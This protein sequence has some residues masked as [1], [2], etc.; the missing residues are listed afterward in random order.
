ML[1]W[2]EKGIE[3]YEAKAGPLTAIVTRDFTYSLENETVTYSLFL[4]EVEIEKLQIHVSEL[5]IN[6]WDDNCGKKACRALEK[7]LKNLMKTWL[8]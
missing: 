7:K 6:W 3:W 5:G 8:K 4:R 1:K 2:Q